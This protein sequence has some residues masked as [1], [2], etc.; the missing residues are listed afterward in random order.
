MALRVTA[1]RK[2]RSPKPKANP[3]SPSRKK[4]PPAKRSP[5]ASK[6]KGERVMASAGSS[7]GLK[8]LDLGTS[9]IV[10]ATLSGEKVKFVPQLNAFVDIPYS[11]MTERMLSNE[12]ILHRIEGRHIYAY[13]NRADEFA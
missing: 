13:G 3:R 8:G 5:A 12:N 7:T 2:R 6:A 10:L 11:K 9:R 1:G 4:T